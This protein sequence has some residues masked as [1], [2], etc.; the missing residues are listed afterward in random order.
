MLG[1]SSLIVYP[2]SDSLVTQ[3][4]NIPLLETHYATTKSNNKVLNLG[5]GDGGK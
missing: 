5:Q 4:I 3:E 1:T 2:F